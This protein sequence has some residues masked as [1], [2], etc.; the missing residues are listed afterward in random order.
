MAKTWRR[1]SAY[2]KMN[3]RAYTQAIGE[4]SLTW[5]ELHEVMSGLFIWAIDPKCSLGME[6]QLSAIWGDIANDRQ[7]RSV[8]QTAIGRANPKHFKAAPKICEDVNWLLERCNSLEDQRNNV[9]HSPLSETTNWLEARMLQVPIG[10]VLPTG[11]GHSRAKKLSAAVDSSN[12]SLLRQIRFYR[13]YAT[14]LTMFARAMIS[15][16]Q[17]TRRAWPAKPAL[18]PLAGMEAGLSLRKA[19]K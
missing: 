9:L 7:K 19:R 3:F 2:T 8:L 5:N 12:R 1:R 6:M 18:P 16:G 15:V 10:E 13:D 11:Q 17:E 14:A 4:F